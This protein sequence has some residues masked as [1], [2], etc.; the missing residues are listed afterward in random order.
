MLPFLEIS[1]RDRFTILYGNDAANRS[2][3]E[4]DQANV[5][6]M[7]VLSSGFSVNIQN[8]MSIRV[9]LR[10]QCDVRALLIS[11]NFQELL[12]HTH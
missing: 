4:P 8:S 3:A 11:Y 2:E 1:R 5:E 9:D 12:S 6:I 7:V 10:S